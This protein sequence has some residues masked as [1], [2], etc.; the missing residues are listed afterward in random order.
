MWCIAGC[1]GRSA[2][3]AAL[4]C[5]PRR[6]DL[7][8]GCC[9]V[10]VP[11][12][13]AGLGL[14]HRPVG[15]APR[16]CWRSVSPRACP[17]FWAFTTLRPTSPRRVLRAT[18]QRFAH[19]GISSLADMGI[20]S[21]ADMG[22]SSRAEMGISSRADMGICSRAVWAPY[23]GALQRRCCRHGSHCAAAAGA[24]CRRYCRRRH[25]GATATRAMPL[26]AGCVVFV[27]FSYD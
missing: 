13:C 18:R 9:A 26:C 22:I 1:S 14:S 3:Y 24:A 23:L 27:L 2:T 20:S 21:R 10:G 15:H 4:R 17:R 25:A 6:P 19:M 11:C 8:D 7:D 12:A 16:R 5:A